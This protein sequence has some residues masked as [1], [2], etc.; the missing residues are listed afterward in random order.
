MASVTLPLSKVSDWKT[1]HEVSS[2]AFGF[3]DYYGH[4]NNAWI[5][6]LSYLDEEG[7]QTSFQLQAGEQLFV[8]ASDYGDFARRC[9]ELADGLNE[10]VGYVNSRYE[11]QDNNQTVVLVTQE[12]A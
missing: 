5:D 11:R 4:N 8:I 7:G 2:I 12:P 9:P 1:F 3:P 6:C 10:L